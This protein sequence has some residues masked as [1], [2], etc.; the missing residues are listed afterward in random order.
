MEI[1]VDPDSVFDVQV[2]RLHAYKRQLL[3]G[4]KILDLYN[5][6]KADPNLP[7]NNYTFI[8]AGKAAQGYVFAKEVIKFINSLADV[9]NSDPDVNQKIKVVFI[10]NFCVSNAQLI[11]PA[12]D[13]SEQIST[14]GKEASGTGNMKFMM[15]GAITLGT[16]DGANVEINQLVGD[17]NMGIFGFSSDE[18]DNFYKHGGYS[19]QRCVDNDPRLKRISEQLV[20]GFFSRCGYDFWGIHDALFRSNDEFFVLGDFDSYVKAW[21]NMDKIYSDKESWNRMSLANIANSAFF[22]SDRTIREYAEEI[23]KAL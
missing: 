14:A 9:I 21:E 12:A 18:V 20:N 4:F 10:E 16:M 11:Y 1:E 8:F 7:I 5:R 3:N 13:I 23:W 15:N 2:K 6:L 17:D 19:A 22:S